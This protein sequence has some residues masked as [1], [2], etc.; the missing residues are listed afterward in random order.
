MGM[1]RPAVRHLIYA[2]LDGII[3]CLT[4][5][6]KRGEILWSLF[7]GIFLAACAEYGQIEQRQP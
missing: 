6:I 3:D 7:T 5:E 1:R 4:S 2:K